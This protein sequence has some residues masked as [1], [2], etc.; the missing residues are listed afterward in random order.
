MVRYGYS[1]EYFLIFEM[2]KTQNIFDI[3]YIRTYEPN[4]HY[5]NL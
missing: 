4:L 1:D 3:N 2:G 5:N